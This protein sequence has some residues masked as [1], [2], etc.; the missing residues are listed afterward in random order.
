[1]FEQAARLK[2]RFETPIGSISAEDLW[3]LPLSMAKNAR[4]GACLDDLAVALHHKLQRET[5]SFVN[6]TPTD[7][8]PQLRFDI[9][10]HIIDVRQA[11][12]KAA[13]EAR[14]KAEQKQKIYAIIARKEDA[15]LEQQDADTLRQLAD[16]L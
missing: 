6:A 14:T 1:M 5:I 16:S 9:V 2:L 13:L 3:D 11:E 12:A 8:R 15:A 7:P 4:G 10:K